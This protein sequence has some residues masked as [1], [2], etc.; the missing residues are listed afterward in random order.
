M[1]CCQRPDELGD[2]ANRG[3]DRKRGLLWHSDGNARRHPAYAAG[4]GKY[5]QSNNGE[6]IERRSSELSYDQARQR[7][8]WDDSE[9]LVGLKAVEEPAALR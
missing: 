9:T 7:K 2:E 8:L 3:H 4:S 5:F 1:A 6:L